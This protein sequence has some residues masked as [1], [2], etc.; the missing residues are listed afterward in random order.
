[1]KKY[2]DSEGCFLVGRIRLN[3]STRV[4]D[5]CYDEYTGD[6][7]D[8]SRVLD[9]EPGAYDCYVTSKNTEFG[10][11]IACLAVVITT[12]DMS[13]KS[14]KEVVDSARWKY[15]CSV[16]NDSGQMGIYSRAYFSRN[17]KCKEWYDNVCKITL[18]PE[19]G[20]TNGKGVVSSSGDGDGYYAISTIERNGKVI[21]IKV[22]FL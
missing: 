22:T 15:R 2:T 20:T 12:D 11:E 3:S 17:A 16:G 5:P 8:I 19:A 18:G 9:T 6:V 10:G 13:S 4:C 7:P 1:M 14:T 21:A